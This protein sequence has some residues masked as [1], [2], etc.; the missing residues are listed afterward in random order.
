MKNL[1]ELNRIRIEK[2]QKCLSEW[3]VIYLNKQKGLLYLYFADEFILSSF[4]PYRS[5]KILAYE[6]RLS[7]KMTKLPVKMLT[8]V[9]SASLCSHA[10]LSCCVTDHLIAACL[11]LQA[12]SPLSRS[13][14]STK[15]SKAVCS[16]CAKLYDQT[17][18]YLMQCMSLLFCRVWAFSVEKKTTNY[19]LTY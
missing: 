2:Y 19:L 12:K 9:C 11:A 18:V 17:R 13:K 1:H 3:S 7:L 6:S 10:C 16:V 8:R 5:T 14:S 15:T 4:F